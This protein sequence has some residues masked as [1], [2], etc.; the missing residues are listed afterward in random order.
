MPPK[1]AAA[2]QPSKGSKPSVSSKLRK[3]VGGA[4]ES[5]GVCSA[6][7]R[8]AVPAR[9]GGTP[10]V[11]AGAAVLDA[12]RGARGRPLRPCCSILPSPTCRDC[13]KAAP[14]LQPRRNS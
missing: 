5:G 6:P 14:P 3:L 2:G 7:G 9:R 11:A 1:E 8:Q 12:P 10:P 13:L 4:V